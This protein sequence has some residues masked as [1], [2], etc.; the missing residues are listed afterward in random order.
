LK[1][2]H[3]EGFI[4]HRFREF[5]LIGAA[6]AALSIT[7]IV[8]AAPQTDNT[9]PPG[10]TSL[11]NGRDFTNWKVPDGDNGHW[12]VMDGVIDYDAASEA[13]GDKALW[14]VKEF[15]DFVLQVDWR[16]KAT[17]YVNPNVYYVLPDGTHARDVTGKEITM[18]LPD[19]DSGI[20]LR[21]SGR[22]Q[23]NIWCWPIGSGEM[24]GWRLD[25][26]QPAEVRAG[27]T[28]RHQ[29]DRPVGQWNHF[30]ITA[31]GDRISV[32]LNGK[33]V[34]ENVR[35]PGIEPRGRIALQHHGGKSGDKWNSPPSL[36]QFKNIYIKE[37]G[38]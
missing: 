33:R 9:A 17:P 14:G 3:R 30:E 28:P 21:G 2:E 27:V 11:F 25:K 34:I 19:S 20:Y 6:A 10:F 8:S 18:A 38:K 5:A 32:E 31:K 1:V 35:L 26:N 24:Y 29:A 7:I 22:N 23:I 36:M 12:K 4:M 37:L 16:I 13:S 15:G